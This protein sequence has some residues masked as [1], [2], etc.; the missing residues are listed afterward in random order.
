[1][2]KVTKGEVKETTKRGYKK[3]E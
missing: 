1:M 2:Q 3:E